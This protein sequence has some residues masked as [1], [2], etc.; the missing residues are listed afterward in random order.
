MSA[1]APLASLSLDLDDRWVYLRTRGA[2]GWE[3]APSYLDAVANRLL[4]ALGQAGPRITCFA[5]GR[6]AADP[7]H[8]G[9]LAVLAAAGHEI[10]NHAYSHDALGALA[11]RAALESEIA[12]AEEAIGAAT[13]RRPL[14]FRG[15]GYV[16]CAAAVETLVARGYAYDATVWPTYL[17]AVANR[18][19]M[20]AHPDRDGPARELF[21]GVDRARLPNRPFRWSTPA[22]DLV[23]IPVTALP[24][25]RF[26]LQV[27]LLVALRS[28]AP[29]LGRHYLRR[30]LALCRRCR[31]EPSLI[32]PPP[33][34]LGAEDAPDLAFFPGMRRDAAWKRAAVRELLAETVRHFTVVTLRE[35]AEAV[36]ARPGARTLPASRLDGRRT[37]PAREA[38]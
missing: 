26:P 34:L 22:G 31:V 38:A 35:H 33:D 17:G 24:L 3:G 25:V 37:A 4:D 15:P 29:A 23:E 36:A 21:G 13:G 8:R 12:R 20:R 19:F 27:S 5:V 16:L 11:G 9:A 2:A 32:L 18:V 6:D 10:G 7:G 1:A 14:G 30:A 28:A